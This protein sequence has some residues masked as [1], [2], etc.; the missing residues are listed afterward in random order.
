MKLTKTGSR[1]TLFPDTALDRFHL[2]IIHERVE[3]GAAMDL[4]PGGDGEIICVDIGC[5]ELV[6]AL[7][8]RNGV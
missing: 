5:H 7:V 6:A 3:S 8:K 2:G 4:S 1:L